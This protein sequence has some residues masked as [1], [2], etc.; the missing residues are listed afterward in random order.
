MTGPFDHATLQARFH[1]ALWQTEP[2]EGLDP[3]RFAVYR[4][5]VQH[6]LSRALATRFP[7]IERLV[8]AEFF[9]RMA[10]VFAAAHPPATPVLLAWGKDFAAFLETFPP[11]AGL[12]YLPDVARLEWA[13]GRAYHAADAP[14]ANPARLGHGDPARLRLTLAPSVRAWASR[15]PALSIW[16]QNQP[17]AVAA[18]LGQAP[19]QALVARTPAFSVI[20]EPLTP[21]G[22]ATLAALLAGHPLGQATMGTDPTPLLTLLLRHG[23]ITAIGD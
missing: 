14:V 3:R 18:P 11:L 19:E 8:G 9:A 21:D 13:R 17:G 4:N 23:L 12:P 1:A 5:N 20:V 15:W 2:P 7:V 16:R 10:R 6:G 22:H